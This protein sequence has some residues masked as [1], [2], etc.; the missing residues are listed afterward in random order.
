LRHEH[1]EAQTAFLAQLHTVLGVCTGLTDDQLLATSRCRGWMAG[2]VLAHVPF[3]LQDML[4]A[5]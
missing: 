4:L 3:G 5:S 1:R 2:D